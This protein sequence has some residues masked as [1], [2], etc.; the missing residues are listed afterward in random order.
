MQD[1]D[2]TVRHFKRGLLTATN[3]GPH[4][5]GSEFTITFGSTPNLDGYQT[6]FGELVE[7]ENIL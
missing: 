2:L 1:E 6:V 7:G 4:A 3:D 5:A